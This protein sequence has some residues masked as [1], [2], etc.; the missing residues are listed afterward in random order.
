MPAKSGKRG[1]KKTTQPRVSKAKAK[2]GHVT[3]ASDVPPESELTPD[4]LP[5]SVRRIQ[6]EGT[7][8]SNTKRPA[9][10]T[11]PTSRADSPAAPP[12]RKQREIEKSLG[13]RASKSQRAPPID[14][15]ADDED[16]ADDI[17]TAFN[18]DG[19]ANPN[20][21]M[22]DP[23][24]SDGEHEEADDGEEDMDLE[25]PRF[26]AIK[27]NNQLPHPTPHP[28]YHEEHNE[29]TTDDTPLTTTPRQ[30]LVPRAGKR[31]MKLWE[32][33]MELES[34]TV[35][36][37]AT[38]PANDAPPAESSVVH[39]WL[40]HTYI[41]ISEHE[42]PVRHQ[43]DKMVELL[44]LAFN[45]ARSYIAFGSTELITTEELT[46]DGIK[47]I[48]TPMSPHGAS[49]YART[50]FVDAC[51]RKMY[52][53]KKDVTT[54]KQITD[55]L[56]DH[57]YIYKQDAAGAIDRTKLYQASIIPFLLK[58][59]FFSKNGA[60]KKNP[61]LFKS[62]CLDKPY[63]HEISPFMMAYV[64]SL[65]E[66]G[67]FELQASVNAAATIDKADVELKGD[68]FDSTFRYH[69]TLLFTTRKKNLPVYHKLMRKH[70]LEV[71]HVKTVADEDISRQ[72]LANM[73]FS[74]IVV[75]D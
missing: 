41:T 64:M 3:A 68:M 1:S 40:E 39:A 17:D 62:S 61:D 46:V 6:I 66:V 29:T 2:P 75:S 14:A 4:S 67:L 13:D 48:E 7:R 16:S 59:A 9:L 54:P 23:S 18:D 32:Q 65:V 26:T 74:S 42:V 72:I 19:E 58:A 5:P 70:L 37:G 27:S 43:N 52:T 56:D 55:L 24:G 21:G 34:A 33:R 8:N 44:R 20:E 50:A 53:G 49:F 15:N 57:S 12:P 63:D 28:H 10:T 60:G 11:A 22:G 45:I 25:T 30:L 69:L 51:K 47:D 36:D 38:N 71:T 35:S 31:R 73:D